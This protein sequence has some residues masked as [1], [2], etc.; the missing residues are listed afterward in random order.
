[1]TERWILLYAPQRLN[2]ESCFELHAGLGVAEMTVRVCILRQLGEQVEPWDM[3]SISGGAS[4]LGAAAG[5]A[6]RGYRTLLEERFDVAK[7]ISSR[8]TK[9]VRGGV[10]Y[11]EQLNITHVMD[12]LRER[13]RMLRNALHLVRDLASFVPACSYSSLPYYGF[14]LMFYERFSGKLPFGGRKH[15]AAALKQIPRYTTYCNSEFDAFWTSALVL[16]CS[17]I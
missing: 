8:S 3:L 6:S 16:G 4:G 7:G 1:M 10:H 9:L 2:P 13:G 5:A 15:S 12:A 17:R 11:L 14:R